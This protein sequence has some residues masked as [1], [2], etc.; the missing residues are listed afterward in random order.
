[1]N[2]QP[3]DLTEEVRQGLQFCLALAPVIICRPI[4]CQRLRCRELYSLGRI[5]R[6]FPLRPPG[7]VDALAY[8]CKLCFRNTCHRKRTNCIC[9]LAASL[10]ST[11]LGHGVLLLSSFTFLVCTAPVWAGAVVNCGQKSFG[12][13]HN[14][15]IG[16]P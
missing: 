8:V 5:G 13:G 6:C 10:C 15:T 7:R 9:L 12:G 3:I 1:M 2:V 11:G 4:A 14:N 16:P